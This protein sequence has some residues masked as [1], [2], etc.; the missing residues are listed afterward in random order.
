MKTILQ[1]ESLVVLSPTPEAAARA[2]ET[3]TVGDQ[4]DHS[5]LSVKTILRTTAM[6]DEVL[7]EDFSFIPD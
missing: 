6:T 7:H 1:E 3:A 5:I 4:W 2:L